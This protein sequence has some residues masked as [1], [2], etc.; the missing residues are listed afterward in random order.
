MGIK[1]YLL[2]IAN[3]L[4]MVP[5]YELVEFMQIND[6]KII[7]KA[8][9]NRS[10]KNYKTADSWKYLRELIS[11]GELADEFIKE[12][13]KYFT[14]GYLLENHHLSYDDMRSGPNKPILRYFGLT[15][16][17]K[18]E[19]PFWF[20]LDHP[21]SYRRLDFT[22]SDKKTTFNLETGQN[23]GGHVLTKLT[24]QNGNDFYMAPIESALS[25]KITKGKLYFGNS[26]HDFD[27]AIDSNEDKE[28]LLVLTS[29][30]T[31]NVSRNVR[32]MKE[33]AR[34]IAETPIE[35]HKEMLEAMKANK[36][37]IN[38]FLA[39]AIGLGLGI[40]IGSD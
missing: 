14:L 40:V 7:S 35:Q 1:K 18:E 33:N 2:I 6:P 21:S 10:E 20:K 23:F 22:T 13:L 26:T 39:G 30:I 27:I 17:Q 34:K 11:S 5:D 12:N 31:S 29:L 9:R 36:S 28:N 3:N 38:P 24:I 37:D 32:Q 16:K 25:F 19:A 8:I 15:E 4:G